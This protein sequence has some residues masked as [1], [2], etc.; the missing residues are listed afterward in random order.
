[1]NSLQ[2]YSSEQLILRQLVHSKTVFESLRKA[3]LSR[4]CD[5]FTKVASHLSDDELDAFMNY[6][7]LEGR[8]LTLNAAIALF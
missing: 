4:Y 2:E 6:H 8:L 1:M 7:V 3:S 5:V